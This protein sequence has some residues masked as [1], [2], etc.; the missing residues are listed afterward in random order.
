MEVK[1]PAQCTRRGNDCRKDKNTHD[2]PLKRHF[3]ASPT[4]EEQTGNSP[5]FA[6]DLVTILQQ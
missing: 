1:A 6:V 4:G 3:H 5:Y 2:C